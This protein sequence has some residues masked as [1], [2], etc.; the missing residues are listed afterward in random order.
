MGDKFAKLIIRFFKQDRDELIIILL[1]KAI[2]GFLVII[3]SHYNYTV[4]RL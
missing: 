1:N 2:N 3:I 4:H